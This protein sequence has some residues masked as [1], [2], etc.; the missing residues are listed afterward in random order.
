M[1]ELLK[2][3]C[4]LPGVSGDEGAVRDFILEQ[5]RP[6]ADEVRVDPMGSV[7]VEKKGRER[8]T[9]R[10][11]LAA[12]MDEVGVI[13][14]RIRDDG[15][16]KF[17]FVGGIDRRVVI[18][19]TVYLGKDRV[20][21]VIGLKA[22]HL[23]HGDEGEKVPKVSDLYIDIGADSREE[24]EKLVRLG[25]TGAFDGESVDFGDGMRKAKAL[26]DRVGCAVL[27]KLI[28]SDLAY[29]T[30]FAFTV[31]EEVGTRGAFGAAFSVQPDIALVVEGTTAADLPGVPEEKQICGPGRGVVIPFMD[32]GTLY[33]REL[34]GVLTGLADE[35]GIP[36]QTK[37]Y[38]AGGTDASAIQRSRAGVRAAGIAVAV[39]YIHSPSSVICLK[40]AEN[41]LALAGAFLEKAGQ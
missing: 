13:V 29:D 17:S 36:W 11:L 31:Q 41:M 19:K 3:L 1:R 38:I 15:Y 8:G 2:K 7:I 6:Y 18:G 26:D 35:R 32:N 24:A 30:T 39:R 20:P 16:L 4:A 28:Q 40:D 25:D 34:F 23:V 12:H 10:V 27:L 33:D 21:G 22:F 37:E 14:T 9:K 5:V